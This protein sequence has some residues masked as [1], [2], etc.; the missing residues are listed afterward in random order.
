M[1]SASVPANPA[2]TAEQG[3]F[4]SQALAARHRVLQQPLA[5]R[6]RGLHQIALALLLSSLL[7]A[8]LLLVQPYSEKVTVPGYAGAAAGQVRVRAVANAVVARIAV[9]EGQWV[10]AGAVLLELESDVV[11]PGGERR[12]LAEQ[13]A[14]GNEA[15][16]LEQQRALLEHGHRLRRRHLQAQ[17]QSLQARKHLQQQ[18]LALAEQRLEL[19]QT[20]AQQYAQLAR[21]GVLATSEAQLQREQVLI[22]SQQLLA[23]QRLYAQQQQDL[24]RQGE[25]LQEQDQQ[26]QEALAQWT[27]DK[28][29][30]QQR[31]ALGSVASAQLLIAP[32]AGYVSALNT[33]EG[34]R[35][36]PNQHVL[37]LLKGPADD[38]A[39]ALLVPSRARGGIATGQTVRLR[40][41]G[42]P[43]EKYGMP[44]GRIVQI[45]Q[46]PVLGTDLEYP[47]APA[48][49]V[50]LA[51]VV[52]PEQ[53]SPAAAPWTFQPRLVAPG[54]QLEA[55]ILLRSE[56]LWQRLAAP[57]ARLWQRTS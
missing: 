22:S 36:R 32:A 18:S 34:A 1:P 52:V 53:T 51:R 9:V 47:L 2:N 35:L 41:A 39:V 23:A 8:S 44:R 27:A 21:S 48:S 7:G 55:D 14:L 40:Y 28:A 15:Q 37:S 29:R 43:Y 45:S 3:L 4:R 6:A 38:A 10:D 31:R 13:R 17:R 20:R 50:Y 30:L 49:W 33:H 46:A 26:H 57:L 24:V 54:M 19:T 5:L 25:R 42:Y 12:G 56:L 16:A 11:A